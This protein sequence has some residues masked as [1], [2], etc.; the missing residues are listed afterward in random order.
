V[1]SEWVL[2]LDISKVEYKPAIPLCGVIHAVAT[3]LRVEYPMPPNPGADL[4]GSVAI[5]YTT[6][7][8]V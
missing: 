2:L 3:T 6:Y 7:I 4:S 1:G 8:E 5:S